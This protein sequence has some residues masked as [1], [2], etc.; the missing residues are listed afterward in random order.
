M[1][2]MATCSW[3]IWEG[4]EEDGVDILGLGCLFESGAV[5]VDMEERV[6]RRERTKRCLDYW[7]C[8]GPV[9]NDESIDGHRLP[10]GA[11]SRCGSV[12]RLSSRRPLTTGRGCSSHP[13]Q[14]P[15]YSTHSRSLCTTFPASVPARRD[16]FAI[17]VISIGQDR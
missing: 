16:T 15:S 1:L 3:R 13:P 14:I 6:G 12:N 17:S 4:Y 7:L 11:C 9:E 2:E 5:S 8:I 10:C